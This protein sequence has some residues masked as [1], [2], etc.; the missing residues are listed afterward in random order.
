M[1]RSTA[2]VPRQDRL[3][4]YLTYEFG[5]AHASG[6]TMVLCD[7][8]VR[9]ISYSIDPLTHRYLGARNDRQPIDASQF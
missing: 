3:S 1:L 4:Y 6:F 9:S 2:T 7:G 5:S 8:S